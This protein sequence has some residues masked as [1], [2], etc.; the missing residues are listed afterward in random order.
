[1]GTEIEATA[2]E[3]PEGTETCDI[4]M[5]QQQRMWLNTTSE[6]LR[7]IPIPGS[8]TE[9]ERRELF[10]RMARNLALLQ[11]PPVISKAKIVSEER[12]DRKIRG[13]S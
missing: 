5:L 7:E 12:E 13:D 4:Y 9:I 8:M 6:T 11:V 3:W 1:M 2:T 10:R